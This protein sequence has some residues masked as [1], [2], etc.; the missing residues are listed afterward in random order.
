MAPWWLR[1]THGRPFVTLKLATSLDG[2]IAM[3]DGSS[4][5]ITGD[6]ARAH[7]HPERALHEG[8]LVG[9]GTDRKSTRLNYSHLCAAR[10][11]S[12]GWK[13]KN[14]QQQAITNRAA[15]GREL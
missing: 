15:R 13:K 12:S 6:R 8:I 5:W 11:P 3:P 7:G 9:R 4:R 1:A 14:E 2:C 10:M